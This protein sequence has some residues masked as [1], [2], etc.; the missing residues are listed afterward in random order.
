MKLTITI[1]LDLT[2]EALAAVVQALMTGGLPVAAAG[3]WLEALSR[4][5]QAKMEVGP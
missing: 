2:P 4:L 3:P 1:T 5:A